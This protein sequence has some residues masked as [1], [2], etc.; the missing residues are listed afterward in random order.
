[1]RRACI[2]TTAG[3]RS[4]VGQAGMSK[5]S[6]PVA[7]RSS[8]REKNNRNQSFFPSRLAPTAQPA[9]LPELRPALSHADMRLCCRLPPVAAADLA[10]NLGLLEDP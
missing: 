4:E 3:L 6:R 7:G 2:Q 10:E 8:T 5:C 1:M 9:F